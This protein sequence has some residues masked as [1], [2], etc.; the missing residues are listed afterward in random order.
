MKQKLILFAFIQLS[1][2]LFSALLSGQTMKE[3]SS[4]A[5]E[6][7]SIKWEINDSGESI[8]DPR[9]VKGGTITLGFMTPPNTLRAYG[10]NSRSQVT[11]LLNS[12]CYESL[13][14]LSP[15]TLQTVPGLAEAWAIGADN[16]TFYFRLNQKA[17]WADGQPVVAEDVR[18]TWDFLTSRGIEDPFYNYYYNK[19]ERPV[20]LTRYVVKIK[21]K[22]M[23]WQNFMTAYGFAIHPAH[24]L[25]ELTLYREDDPLFFDELKGAVRKVLAQTPGEV[26]SADSVSEAPEDEARA[27]ELV[28]EIFP[29]AVPL[30]QELKRIDAEQY[31]KE[32]SDI[33][34]E[35]KRVVLYNKSHPDRSEIEQ[36]LW[37]MD[38]RISL[39]RNLLKN[40]AAGAE[41]VKK[42]KQDLESMLTELD[43]LR[44]TAVDKGKKKY[45]DE[46]QF[47]MMLG[48]GP[49]EFAEDKF[50]KGEEIWIRRR[51]NYWDADNP[52]SRYTYNFDFWKFVIIRDENLIFEK[53]KAGEI[54]LAVVRMSKRWLTE[55]DFD[56]VDMGWIKKKKVFTDYARGIS[57][58]AFNMRREPFDDVRIRK[59]F[60][61]LLNIKELVHMT[62]YDEYDV[63]DSYFPASMYENPENEKIR[64]NPDLGI[65][66]LAEAGWDR[67]D[68]EGRLCNKDMKPFIVT[69]P[70][71]DDFERPMVI[72]Q[73]YLKDVGIT[74][75]LKLITA[76]TKWELIMERKFSLSYQSWTGTQFPAPRS[77]W[78]SSMGK[79]TQTVN[80]AGVSDEIVDSIVTEYEKFIPLEERIKLLRKL[81]KRLMELCPYALSYVAKH[82]RLI[83]WDKFGM[84]KSVLGKQMTSGVWTGIF[85]YW[86]VDPDKEA[87]LKEAVA[88]NKPLPL[89][90]VVIRFWDKWKEHYDSQLDK[91]GKLPPDK[92]L[93]SIW[94]EFYDNYVE[95][96]S[97]QRY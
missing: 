23:D 8:A 56:K 50:K 48:S 71:T 38:T 49:Y 91:D 55:C 36:K 69:I 81:D 73:E 83:Y 67:W 51:G 64:Y 74:L 29:D 79:K 77:M 22:T 72:M 20:V 82:D 88:N 39:S 5:E 65:K 28:S 43:S 76:E 89:E 78:H 32:I 17:R 47:K 93:T 35:G 86:W 31:S 90:P 14:G 85:P 58:I 27:L 7:G 40:N 80:I 59:A 60:R 25:Y 10:P 84:P 94:R 54:D 21:S 3:F 37:V 30:L 61:Y 16:M 11:T 9:A 92:T 6:L 24:K 15:I 42:V 66:L 75:K 33:M 52:E 13:C 12:G 57:G 45:T 19:F 46:Y 1:M 96:E 4:V 87:R 34:K 41:L 70:Y 68:E 63:L 97:N 53:F 2:M 62:M 26:K 18:A 44:K 95:P